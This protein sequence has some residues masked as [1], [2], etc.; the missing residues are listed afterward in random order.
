MKVF[1]F[2]I[3]K[4]AGCKTVTPHRL[5]LPENTVRRKSDYA[6][7]LAPDGENFRGIN[8]VRVLDEEKKYN[9]D[10]VIKA[11]YD[12]RLSAFEI[13]IPALINAL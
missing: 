2:I 9:L 13:F 8:A 12:T 5:P 6:T 10:K 4:T 3:R 1:I 11:G 7:Y